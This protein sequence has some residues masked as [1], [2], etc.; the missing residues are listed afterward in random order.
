MAFFFLATEYHYRIELGGAFL[1]LHF[2]FSGFVDDIW[3]SKKKGG[4]EGTGGLRREVPRLFIVN[5]L[6][7]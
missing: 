2:F 6:S 7:S 3:S 1:Y 4:G 5:L